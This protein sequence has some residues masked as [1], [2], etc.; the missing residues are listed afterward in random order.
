M[1]EETIKPVITID[2]NH[3]IRFP[4][5]MWQSSRMH[6]FLNCGQIKFRANIH[7]SHVW[8]N[9]K[10]SDFNLQQTLD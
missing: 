9:K 6:F 3:W 8:G 2:N 5:T 10:T 1:L 7:A 4:L